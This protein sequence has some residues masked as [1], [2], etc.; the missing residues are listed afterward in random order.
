M[1]SKFYCSYFADT[2]IFQGI[3]MGLFFVCKHDK[4]KV[5]SVKKK[6]R[7]RSCI[8]LYSN[9]KYFLLLNVPKV[10]GIAYFLKKKKFFE[11]ECKF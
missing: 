3:Q 6:S 5:I 11:T 7:L 2:A 10:T 4:S 8:K 1:Y 9:P